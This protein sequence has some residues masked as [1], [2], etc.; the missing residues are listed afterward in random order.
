MCI[1]LAQ[2]GLVK[3]HHFDATYDE[4]LVLKTGDD[5]AYNETT[6]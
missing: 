4:T 1:V 5:V 6:Y 2:D 3:L